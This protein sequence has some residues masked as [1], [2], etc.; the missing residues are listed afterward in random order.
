MKSPYERGSV[1]LE[2]SLVIFVRIQEYSE[3]DRR[4]TYNVTMRRVRVS[5]VMVEKK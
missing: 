3:Q 1:H 2:A 5:S 4:Y